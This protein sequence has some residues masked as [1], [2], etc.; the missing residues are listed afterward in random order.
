MSIFSKVSLTRPP[1]ST[2]NLSHDRKFS[3]N[4]GELIPCLVQECVPGDKFKISTSQMLR[5]MPMLSPVMH[6][7]NVFTHFYFVP[8]RLLWDNWEDFITGGENGLD[9]KIFPTTDL[10]GQ[11]Y[12]K[13]QNDV[14]SLADYLGLPTLKAEDPPVPEKI[15]LLPFLA[16]QKIYNEYYR[17]QNLI[18]EVD[19]EI[20][21]GLNYRSSIGELLKIRRRAWNHDYFTSA[22]PFAQKGNAVRLPLGTSASIKFQSNGGPTYLRNE[23]GSPSTNQNTNVISDDL[24]RLRAE[25]PGFG[26]MYNID[27]SNNLRADLT[28]ATSSTVND[29][30]R[31]FKLQEW[32]EKNARAGSRYIE[33]IATHFGVKSSDSRLQRPEY[34]GGGM[35]PVLISEVL[36]TSETQTTPLGEMG[37]HGLN[38][39]GNGRIS[40]YCEEHGFIIGIISVMPKAAYQQGIPR[41]YSKTDKFDYFWPEFQHIG[42][43]AILSKELF[44]EDDDQNN[45]E[46]FGYIPRYAEYK[47][48]PSTVHGYFKTSLDFWHMG[49][50]FSK[51][52]PPALNKQFVECDPTRRVFAVEDPEEDVLLVHMY[53][54]ISARRLMSYYGEPSFK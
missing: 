51:L 18:P 54:N 48:N 35:S 53:H 42:E 17:D 44:F 39:G 16:Y 15:N 1:S 52:Y 32:L 20:T 40:K 24:G 5:M 49:R 25:D 11:G 3:M 36:Q 10:Y 46:T 9:A 41:L 4:M 38:L 2:F 23:D 28:D 31:A 12:S 26:S 47:Y 27:N 21:D 7:V 37:G 33:S 50:I 13:D 34:I 30:R 6:E 45:Q 14:G 29:L 8:N 43:Q 19:L 22:L